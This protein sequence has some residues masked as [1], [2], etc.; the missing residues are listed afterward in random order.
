MPKTDSISF[1]AAAPSD[2]AT[3]CALLQRNKLGDSDILAA[4]TSYWIAEDAGGALV[5]CIGIEH[6]P[7]AALLRSALVDPAWR[8]QGIGA[9]LTRLALDTAAHMACQQIY[10]FSTGAGAYW[11]RLGFSEV[12]VAELVNALPNAPQVRLYHR[13]GWLP[14]EIAWRRTVAPNT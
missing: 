8:G 7:A 4:G 12:P 11:A 2:A 6:G 10:L 14:T 9:A 13:K 3:I 5:G 1:R